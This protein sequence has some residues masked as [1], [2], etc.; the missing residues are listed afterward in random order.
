MNGCVYLPEVRPVAWRLPGV[1]GSRGG[2]ENN[3]KSSSPFQGVLREKKNQKNDGECEN[4]LKSEGR[5]LRGCCRKRDEHGWD[6]NWA[7]KG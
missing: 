1:R 5:Q 2:P 7:D 6:G 3:N 4:E